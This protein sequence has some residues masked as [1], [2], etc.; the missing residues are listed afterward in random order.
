MHPFR[1]ELKEVKIF[2]RSD[3]VYLSIGAGYEEL[4]EMHRRLDRGH[5]HIASEVWEYSP[6][7]TL[8]QTQDAYEV[9][10]RFQVA[11]RRWR[12]FPYSRSF[13]LEHV[14]FVQNTWGNRWRDLE[15]YD[16]AASPL[17]KR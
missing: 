5:C 1:V 13:M 15:H 2:G 12:E 8:L 17:A 7:I 14:C 9:A 10:G 11:A 3:V 4:R 6:H 16:L